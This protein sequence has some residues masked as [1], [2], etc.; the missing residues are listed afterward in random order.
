MFWGVGGML[1]FLDE[2]TA[3]AAEMGMDEDLDFLL[4]SADVDDMRCDEKVCLLFLCGVVGRGGE[5]S[6][7]LV[8]IA[9]K[10][11][12]ATQKRGGGKRRSHPQLAKKTLS[13][14]HVHTGG[15]ARTKSG[16]AQ[17]GQQKKRATNDDGRPHG[18]RLV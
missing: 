16:P 15:G 17:P 14:P 3:V 12:K 18:H 6:S 9:P 13:R 2:G 10:K 8:G 11:K 1:L 7:E 5:K 4:L